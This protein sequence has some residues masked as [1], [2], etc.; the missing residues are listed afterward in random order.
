MSAKRGR[1]GFTLIELLVVIA[2]IA[3]LAA[4]LFPV[5][6]QAREKARQSNCLSNFRNIAMGI[7]QYTNDYDECLVPLMISPAPFF[8]TYDPNQGDYVW[9][10]LTHPYIK[11][12]QIHRCPSDPQA[13]DSVLNE[14][15]CRRTV[16]G[17]IWSY[18][19]GIKT[20]AGYN[21]VYLSPMNRDAKSIGIPLA[22]IAN[23]A[24]TLMNVDSTWY[25]DTGG[26]AAGGGNWFVDPPRPTG[27]GDG[28]E[29]RYWFG[30]WRVPACPN[31]PDNYWAKYG[32]TWPRHH[33]ENLTGGGCPDF[34]PHHRGRMNVAFV[35]GHA[36]SLQ[37]SD[38]LRGT[39]F[40]GMTYPYFAVADFAAYIWDI[41]Q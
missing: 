2:I 18:C 23:P 26:N 37:I 40:I 38:L 39:T 36:K 34:F 5:F 7:A 15:W 33:Y 16:G 17:E 21:H 13:T 28:G 27:C 8:V 25:A 12:W 9:P 20:D 14:D 41:R 22:P 24:N 6:S 19:W 30:G 4:I 1:F 11:N 35:D 32:G 31:D 3:I 29:C 10:E